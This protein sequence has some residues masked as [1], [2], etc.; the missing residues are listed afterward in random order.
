MITQLRN[1]LLGPP[2]PMT[3]LEEWYWE[4]T[5]VRDILSALFFERRL[6]EIFSSGLLALFIGRNGLSVNLLIIIIVLW[7]FY[8]ALKSRKPN[9][10]PAYQLGRMVQINTQKNVNDIEDS[11]W[12]FAKNSHEQGVSIASL[13]QG[14]A[15]IWK[16]LNQS[17]VLA[18]IGLIFILI[19]LF[20]IPIF[21]RAWDL[22]IL[23]LGLVLIVIDFALLML[24]SQYY[25]LYGDVFLQVLKK[26]AI[27]L[28]YTLD[29]S[30]TIYKEEYGA[31][32]E[33][34]FVIIL[35]FLILAIPALIVT[36]FRFP[37][38][39]PIVS[40]LLTLGFV[41]GCVWSLI[42]LIPQSKSRN[43]LAREQTGKTIEYISKLVELKL[44]R[45]VIGDADWNRGGRES[46]EAAG[47]DVPTNAVQLGRR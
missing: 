42:L 32:T 27:E 38:V 41:F 21:T 31:L 5:G 10:H 45:D 7:L 46:L 26:L 35:R 29:L 33:S 36:G 13:I 4:N 43:E 3:P 40:V 23:Y 18:V 25:F 39:L 16:R 15:Y 6:I 17:L 34:L 22:Y 19:N 44:R 14:Q 20:G 47:F 28:E 12:N 8:Y 37:E 9:E 11:F 1:L 2:E 24:F 30:G